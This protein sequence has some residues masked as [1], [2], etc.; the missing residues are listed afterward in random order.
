M[1]KRA[2]TDTT[3]PKTG[4]WA[5]TRQR[6]GRNRL[7]LWSLRCVYLMLGL[8]LISD[9]VANDKPLYCKIDGEHYFPVLK[10]Y[11]V[12][13]GLSSWPAEFYS[14]SWREQSYQRVIWPLVPYSA[15]TIDRR[16]T[17]FVGPFD[18]QD[19]PSLRFRHWLGTD[20]TGRDVAAGMISGLRKA[21]L[22]GLLSMAIAAMI[23]LSLGALAGYFGDEGLRLNRA[24]LFLLVLVLPFALFYAFISRSYAL[25]E[26]EHPLLEWSIS[27]M[28][29]IG[30]LG[31]AM[32]AARFLTR[33]AFFK[34]RVKIP[35]DLLIMRFIETM[36][37]IPVLLLVLAIAALL[38]TP[39]ILYIILLIGFLRWTT[40]AR[41]VRGELLRIR[42]LPY[43]EAARAL[44]Y[45]HWRIITRHAIPNALT[46][47]FITV[48]FGIASAILIEASLS[49]LGIGVA[50]EEVT[51]GSMLSVARRNFSAWW[52][53]VF[54]GMAIFIT[55]TVFNLIGD[56]LRDSLEGGG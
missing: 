25:S 31:L 24:Q 17:A 3:G 16:N 56:G 10:Q 12:S 49:F 21:L 26:S 53:A 41:F 47:V 28:I 38:P 54:P 35:V 1:K 15:H 9:F 8:A 50:L 2:G 45:R 37:S 52:L 46:P 7:A 51:W 32:P 6:F 20:A 55:V 19:V 44:G 39:S 22:V 33:W 5:R 14:R 11:A 30:L 48:A 29:L 27:L 34:R 40:I 23:G 43:I 18:Q 42:Q 4:F 36:N 13:A